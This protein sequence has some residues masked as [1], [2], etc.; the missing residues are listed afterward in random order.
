[1]NKIPD[2]DFNSLL[3]DG[4]NSLLSNC[5]NEAIDASCNSC[6]LLFGLTNI[7]LK[8]CW[9]ELKAVNSMLVEDSCIW[10]VMIWLSPPPSISDMQLFIFNIELDDCRLIWPLVAQLVSG[11]SRGAVVIGCGCCTKCSRFWW[12]RQ[13]Y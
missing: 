12:T 2:I 9:D 6:S 3:T 10:F 4:D 8:G 11:A 7:E 13:F 1:M 5:L